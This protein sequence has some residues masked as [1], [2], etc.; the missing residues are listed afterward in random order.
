MN[1][2]VRSDLARSHPLPD[3]DGMAWT[4]GSAFLKGAL[5]EVSTHPKPGLVTPRSS[6]S[7]DDMD[8]QTFMV[9][10]AAIAPCFYLCAEAGLSHEGGEPADLLPIVRLIGRQFETRLLKSTGGINTQRGLLFSAGIL[11][12]SAGIVYRNSQMID[13]D[14]LFA[15]ASR[16]T[17]GICDREL[18]SIDIRQPATAGEKLYVRHGVL[19]IRGEVEAGFP[20]VRQAGLPA[21]HAAREQSAPLQTA[22]LHTL[23]SLM[24]VMEDTTVLW[25]GDW[26]ALAFVRAKAQRAL[27]MGGALTPDGLSIIADLDAECIARNI[28]PGGAADLLAITISVD[29]L[30]SDKTNPDTSQAG[31]PVGDNQHER[32]S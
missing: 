2:A 25:R 13:A 16:M 18:R 4:I 19:G 1:Y 10:S 8:L 31:A 32:I 14:E 6:G 28:S 12:A 23:I 29:S 22:L 9:S 20:T 21:L 5:L 24:A 15:V 7:H 3:C 17:R 27:D 30:I 26:P 11:S